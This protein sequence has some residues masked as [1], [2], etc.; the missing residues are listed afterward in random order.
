MEPPMS[1]LS[2]LK[3]KRN[4]DETDILKMRETVRDQIDRIQ[5]IL[6]QVN[7]YMLLVLRYC[8]CLS[9]SSHLFFC[10][11]FLIYNYFFQ[12]ETLTLFDQLYTIMVTW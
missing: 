5:V 8:N 2:G 6:K 11:L 10:L 3:F 4:L 12:T 7:P 1:R 9:N